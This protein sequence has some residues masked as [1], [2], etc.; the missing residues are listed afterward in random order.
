MLAVEPSLFAD[1]SKGIE[2]LETALKASPASVVVAEPFLFNLCEF[3][4]KSVSL[5]CH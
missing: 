3:M 2:A 5:D 4:N 1:P